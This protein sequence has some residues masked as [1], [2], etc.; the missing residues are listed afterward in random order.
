MGNFLFLIQKTL[1]SGY[2]NNLVYLSPSKAAHRAYLIFC[3][4]RKGRIQPQ[5]EAYLREAR[6]RQENV[7]GHR[8]QTYNWKGQG[9]KVLLIHGWESNTFRWRNL[10]EPLTQADFDV[11]A[12]DAPAHGAS[13][14]KYLHVPLYTQCVEHL[15]RTFKPDHLIGHS[16]G[17][18]TTL[19]HT[20]RHPNPEIEKIVTIGAPS[21][22]HEIM[23]NYQKL[24]G[25][26]D[27][28]LSAL[29]TYIQN[30]FG[31]GIRDFSTSRFALEIDKPGLL[32]HDRKDAV[33]PYSASVRVN[34]NWKGSELISTEGLGHSMHQAEVNQKIVEFLKTT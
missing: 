18:M 28:V 21:E 33:A 16:V 8:I 22:F 19:Y 1:L 23:E 15:V 4:V 7:A 5:Q 24:L 11:Y 17:G 26:N 3:K 9:P 6:L 20:Y 30:R 32:L 31:F 14:G 2:L 29:D 13:S 27:R 34:K 12:F 10:I 25:F